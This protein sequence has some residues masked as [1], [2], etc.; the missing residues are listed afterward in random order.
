MLNSWVKETVSAGGTGNLTLSGADGTDRITANAAF[1]TDFPFRYFIE[2]GNDRESGWG[3]LSASTTLVRDAIIETLVSGTYDRTS[4][5]A[6][7]VSASAKV[8]CGIGTGAVPSCYSAVSSESAAYIIPN[9]YSAGGAV[10]LTLTADRMYYWP[11]LFNFC[12]EITGAVVDVQTNVA[13][14]NTRVGLYTI[15]TDGEPENLI[16]ETGDIDSG[17]SGTKTAAWSGGGTIF[18]YPGWYYLGA[19]S[20]GGIT[21]AGRNKEYQ[22][23]GGPHGVASNLLESH[24]VLYETLSLWSALPDPAAASSSLL[25]I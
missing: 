21:L 11:A 16:A 20:D 25:T 12:G 4:P 24:A 10:N 9:N 22:M 6:I 1:G 5:S 7:N 19:V 17:T 2:D 3:H 15:G 18:L 14:S 8:F 13:L 23:G